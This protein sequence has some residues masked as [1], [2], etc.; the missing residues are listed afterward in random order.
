MEMQWPLILFTAFVAW[1][2]GLFGTG[3]VLA[4]MGKA[5][6]AQMPMLITSVVLLTIGGIAVFFHLEHWERI[7]NGFGHLSSG[8]TQE[9]IAIV[10]LAIVMVAFFVMLRKSEDGGTVPA[11]LGIIGAI[12]AVALVCVAGAS[13]LMPARP[14][15]DSVTQIF[16]LLGNTLV[17]GPLT[18]AFIVSLK[19][20][21]DEAARATVAKFATVGAAVN[22]LTCAIFLAVMAGAGDTLTDV[23][24]YFDPTHPTYGMQD[25]AVASP[26]VGESVAS[27]VVAIIGSVAALALAG[28]GLRGGAPLKA[29][30]GGGVVC[31]VVGAIALRMAFYASGLSMFMFY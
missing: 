29:L 3:S 24:Y 14:A 18:A 20:A 12:A 6:K 10:V 11:V 2:A 25:A 7:F 5:K 19:D 15:W 9:L 26:F 23:G 22:V 1:S 13:Y 4:A 30:A 28:L 8:I 31:A 16:S 21:D 27:A 17:L